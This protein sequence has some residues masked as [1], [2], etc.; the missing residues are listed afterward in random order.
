MCISS[1]SLY[2]AMK[3]LPSIAYLSNIILGEAPIALILIKL[4]MILF[5]LMMHISI[6]IDKV[7]FSVNTIVR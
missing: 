2:I 5:G 4:K 3:E 7:D 1:F 6:T